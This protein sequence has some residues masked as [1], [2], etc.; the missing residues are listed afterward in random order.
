MPVKGFRLP[1]D[2]KFTF[3]VFALSAVFKLC[4]VDGVE[5]QNLE[6][7]RWVLVL[8]IL[9]KL[10]SLALKYSVSRSQAYGII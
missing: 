3:V 5:E 1:F 2:C 6:Q 9:I 8:G 4:S 10:M 7:R